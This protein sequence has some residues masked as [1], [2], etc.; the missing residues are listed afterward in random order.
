MH[1]M[2]DTKLGFAQVPIVQTQLFGDVKQ[3][4]QFGPLS[5]P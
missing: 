3:A 4:Q 1:A 5:N 2:L